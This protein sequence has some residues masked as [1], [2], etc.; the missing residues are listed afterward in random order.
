[1]YEHTKVCQQ[2]SLLFAALAL[3]PELSEISKPEEDIDYFYKKFQQIV[4]E[5]QKET[6]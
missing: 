4:A 1:M 6:K 5:K 2:L 3:Q